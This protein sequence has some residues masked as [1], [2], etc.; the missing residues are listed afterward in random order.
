M[1]NINLSTKMS[2]TKAEIKIIIAKYNILKRIAVVK[3]RKIIT[4]S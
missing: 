4:K 3:A 2:K 1:K